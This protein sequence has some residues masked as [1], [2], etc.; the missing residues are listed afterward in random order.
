MKTILTTLLIAFISVISFNNSFA[1]EQAAEIKKTNIR[2][3]NLHC[4]N[5]MPTIKAQ[6]LKQDGVMDVTFTE[7]KTEMSVFTIKY[8]E[9][10]VDKNAIEKFIEDTPGCDDKSSRPY[11]VVKGKDKENKKI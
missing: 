11:K 3:R 10:A 7:R 9:G 5:D 2:V 1:Q 8:H 6:L 4:N